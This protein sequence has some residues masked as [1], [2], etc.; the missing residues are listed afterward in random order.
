MIYGQYKNLEDS[1]WRCLLD[2]KIDRLP[3]DLAQ[4]ARLARIKLHEN[5]DAIMLIGNEIGRSF[6]IE[7]Q[8]HVVYDDA[9]IRPRQRVTIAH[10]FGHI[11]LGHMMDYDRRIRNPGAQYTKQ[12]KAADMFAEHLLAP[13]CVLWALNARTADEIA[14]LCNICPVA[15]KGRA[16]DMEAL[17]QQGMLLSHPLE[18]QVR[19]KFAKFI[20]E[21][22]SV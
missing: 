20:E 8:W 5:K 9:C 11:F 18:K 21:K 15:A 19:D 22:K 16:Q 6:Y 1:S 12:E 7:E 13:A 3:V 4:I 17:Y 2:Y 10:E 14:A